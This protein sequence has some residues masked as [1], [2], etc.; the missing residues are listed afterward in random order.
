MIWYQGES[1]RYDP[2][3]YRNL[4]PAL[5]HNWRHDWATLLPFYFVQIAP[6][7]YPVAHAGAGIREAQ[8]MTLK[9]P[10]TGMAVTMDIGNPDDIHPTNKT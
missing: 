5:I 3:L 9:V 7:N 10:S 4:F 6:F 1:N 8:M 2:Y